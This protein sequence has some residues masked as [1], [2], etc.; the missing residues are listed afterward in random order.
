LVAE[1]RVGVLGTARIA[2]RI[3]ADMQRVEGLAVVAIGS[4]SKERASWYAKQYGVA[5][6]VEDYGA[7]LARSDIDAV[8]IPLPP[9]LH[10]PWCI[11]AANAGKHLLCEKPLACSPEEADAIDQ[12]CRDAGVQWLDATAWLHHP[13]SQ[14]IIDWVQQQTLGPLRHVSASVSF[15]EPFQAN[16]HRLMHSLGG[17]CLL[18][19][20]WYTAGLFVAV[21]GSMNCLAATA[22]YEGD[23]SRHV[24]ALVTNEDATITG[25]LDCGFDT[26]TRKWFE[27][28]GTDA[29]AVCDDFTRPWPDRPTRCWVHDRAGQVKSHTFSNEQEQSMLVRW[30][31][32]ILGRVDLSTLQQ[33]ALRTQRAIA[34]IAQRL[35]HVTA[36]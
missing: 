36:S 19:L 30:R 35:S 25:T 5:H 10:A 32:A 6:A 23:I 26:A 15:F 16:D 33:Q 1:L 18:D 31:D 17:G 2:R 3:I 8:Y 12:A 24:A 13:R 34:A 22:T 21:A 11:A 4:R 14:Q 28:A 9:A 27:V 29:S 7:L 20:G